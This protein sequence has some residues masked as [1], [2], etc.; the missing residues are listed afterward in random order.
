LE[1]PSGPLSEPLSEPRWERLT[2]L[3][4]PALQLAPPLALRLPVRQLAPR[5]PAPR[6]PV[7][8]LEQS[9]LLVWNRPRR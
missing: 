1:R 8:R 2:E 6:L 7:P 4:L 3:Q 9:S 5:L